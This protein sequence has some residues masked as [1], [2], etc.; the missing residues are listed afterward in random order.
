M[1]G[2]KGTFFCLK[3]WTRLTKIGKG[4]SPLG[5]RCPDALLLLSVCRPTGRSRRGVVPEGQQKES[6]RTAETH[7]KPTEQ[8]FYTKHSGPTKSGPSVS[9]KM[10]EGRSPLDGPLAIAS[11]NEATE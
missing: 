1:S 11:R 5:F 2:P 6:R 8:R 4:G 3:S 10:T 7:G 9:V